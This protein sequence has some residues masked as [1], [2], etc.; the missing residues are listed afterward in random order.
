ME[1]EQLVPI[2]RKGQN[3]QP[4]GVSEQVLTL[5][6]DPSIHYPVVDGIPV[7]LGPERLVPT[8]SP[9]SRCPVVD[10]HDPMYREAY[11]ESEVYNA[12][13]KAKMLELAHDCTDDVD[14]MEGLAGQKDI[15]SVAL[16]FPEPADIWLEVGYEPGGLFEAYRYLAPVDGKT[17]M[18]VGGTG[19][20]AVK[21]LLAGARSGFLLTPMLDEARYAM[22]LA[23]VFGVRDRFASV[24][25][26]GEQIPFRGDLF[27]LV[28]SFSCL[29]H[30]RLEHVAGELHRV[31][32]EGG[33]FASVDPWKTLLHTIGTAALG[34]QDSSVYCRPITAKRM[35]EMREWFPD[36]TVG[37]HGPLLRYLCLGLEKLS[38]G[39][40]FPRSN[41]KYQKMLMRI[42]RADDA[43]GRFIGLKGGIIVMMGT[44]S[45]LSPNHS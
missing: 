1:R 18:Q 5:K 11:E 45:A 40:F 30:M 7:L 37:R 22:R 44:K 25:G 16:S 28:C 35:A 42:M 4:F 23:E 20:H 24:V 15:A 36:I 39:R 43:L 27:N 41:R 9:L 2:P 13:V 33:K 21:L 17:V 8:D 3:A 26:V 12:V 10:L 6:H 29:H 14:Y 31:L 32:K 19:A 34:K 38:G